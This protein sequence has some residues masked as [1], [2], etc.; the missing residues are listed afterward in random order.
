MLPMH[1]KF[2]PQARQLPSPNNTP[3]SLSRLITK[4]KQENFHTYYGRTGQLGDSLPRRLPLFRDLKLPLAIC[5]EHLLCPRHPVGLSC[6]LPTGHPLPVTHRVSVACYP[7]GF[8]CLLPTGFPCLLPTGLP[9]PATHRA[10]VPVTHRT[11]DC[12]L[13]TGLPIACFTHRTSVPALTSRT[14]VACSD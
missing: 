6:L 4:T 14:F 13:P 11:S 1:D 2:I 9:L 10:S 8:R 3:S 7:Q 5:L 12:L